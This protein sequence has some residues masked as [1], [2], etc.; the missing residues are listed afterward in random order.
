MSAVRRV[1]Q[2]QPQETGKERGTMRKRC[3]VRIMLKATPILW[4]GVTIPQSRLKRKV[5]IEI[6]PCFS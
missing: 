6:F 2:R 5:K 4:L 3:F 1:E